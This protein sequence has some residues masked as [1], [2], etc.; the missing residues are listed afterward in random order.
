MGKIELVIKKIELE[1]TKEV[2][3][4]SRF[5][6]RSDI[7]YAPLQHQIKYGVYASLC[8]EIKEVLI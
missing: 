4:L 1:M 8:S 2:M 6:I 3:K 5:D 7:L